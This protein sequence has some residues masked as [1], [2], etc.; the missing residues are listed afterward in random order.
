MFFF[1]I[2]KIIYLNFVVAYR[3]YGKKVI[4]CS[5]RFEYFSSITSPILQSLDDSFFIIESSLEEHGSPYF[6]VSYDLSKYII[7]DYFLCVEVS[8]I[9]F[10]SKFINLQIDYGL[11]RAWYL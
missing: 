2:I 1:K 3:S 5:Y 7:I 6:Q 4:L 11:P 9:R 8:G 10:P